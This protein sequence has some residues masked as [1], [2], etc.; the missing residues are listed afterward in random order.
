MRP[1]SQG[2]EDGRVADAGITKMAADQRV[3]VQVI[4]LAEH[5]RAGERWLYRGVERGA[6]VVASRYL[7]GQYG[8]RI[9]L[10]HADASANRLLEALHAATEAPG[11]DAVDVLVQPH[12]TSR[13]LV[14]ADG[15]IDTNDLA[16]RAQASLR[17]AQRRRLRVAIS[18]ACFG[19]THNDAWLRSGFAAAV[20]A[21][22][23]YADG[24]S[25]V[26]VLLRTWAKGDTLER[27]VAMA[28]AG[29]VARGQDKLAAQY[30]RATGRPSEAKEVDSERLVDGARGMTIATDP[31]RW[32][33]GSLPA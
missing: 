5:V 10:R 1:P 21:R 14:L 9:L 12:G 31:A 23:I 15:P 28:N 24:F 17:P 27:A 4:S 33:P 6:D 11:V 25:S 13:R 32:R 18:T 20:G 22:G 30:Y 3:L 7:H 8:T 16:A 29:R 2:C 26:P 19:M